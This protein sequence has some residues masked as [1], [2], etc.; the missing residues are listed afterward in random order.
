MR[1]GVSVFS[2]NAAALM[3]QGR[4]RACLHM[5]KLTEVLSLFSLSTFIVL[6]STT[7]KGQWLPEY[8]LG[9]I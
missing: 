9:S 3:G 7:G 8:S 2:E 1:E 5:K 4:P 6:S